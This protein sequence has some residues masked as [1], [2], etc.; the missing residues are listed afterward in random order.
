MIGNAAYQC[1]CVRYVPDS[2]NM[3][4]IVLIPVAVVLL[5]VVIANIAAIAVHLQRQRQR[6]PPADIKMSVEVQTGEDL[7]LP[8]DL[9]GDNVYRIDNE[10]T[11]YNRQLPVPHDFN[12]IQPFRHSLMLT[13]SQ[14]SNSS[15]TLATRLSAR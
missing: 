15:S 1:S 4:L 11:Y 13:R 5:F 10:D 3:A 2:I 6:K 7:P 9:P 8:E 12:Y 14:W